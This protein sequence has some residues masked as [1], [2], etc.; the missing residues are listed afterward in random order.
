MEGP[1][2]GYTGIVIQIYTDNYVIVHKEFALA[3]EDLCELPI[4]DSL[5]C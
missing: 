1:S 5:Q 3:K 2:A 4:K